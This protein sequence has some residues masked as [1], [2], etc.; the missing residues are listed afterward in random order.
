MYCDSD[1]WIRLVFSAWAMYHVHYAVEC[2]RIGKHMPRWSKITA[3]IFITTAAY[4]Q[5]WL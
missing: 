2:L 5:G 4:L 3:A 1:C